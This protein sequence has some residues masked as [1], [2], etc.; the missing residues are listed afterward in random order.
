MKNSL[1]WVGLAMG[2]LLSSGCIVAVDHHDSGYDSVLTVEWTI[3]DSQSSNRCTQ[4]SASSAEITVSSSRGFDEHRIVD[5]RDF[6]AD[7]YV[8]PGRYRVTVQLLDYD[9]E[10]RTTAATADSHE[11]YEDVD[12]NVVIDFGAESFF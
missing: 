8:P 1:S 4:S 5:C 7:F 11:I 3:N 6:G 2:S 12:D 9:G 10:P